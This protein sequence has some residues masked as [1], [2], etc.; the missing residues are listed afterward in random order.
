MITKELWVQQIFNKKPNIHLQMNVPIPKIKMRASIIIILLSAIVALTACTPAADDKTRLANLKKEK[1][2]ID[3]EIT[4]LEKKNPVKADS[5]VITTL[6]N[7]AEVKTEVFKHYLEIQ[8]RIESDQNI[9]VT[10]KVSGT[11]VTEVLVSRGQSVR[12]GQLLARLDKGSIPEQLDELN[13]GIDLAQTIYN[14]QKALWDQKIGTEI[15]Y[16]Q[17]KNTLE[18][19]RR[20]KATT[21]QMISNY[22]VVAPI[23]GVVDDLT[24]RVGE[25]PTPGMDGVRI[26]N[27]NKTKALADVSE[28]YLT[29]INIGDE[30]ILEFP[31][32]N[33]SMKSSVKTVGRAIN[34]VNRTFLVEFAMN[35]N[36]RELRPNM[37]AVIKINDYTNKRVVTVPISVVQNDEA[38][39][40]IYVVEESGKQKIARKRTITVGQN[41]G[42]KIEVLSGLKEN[43]KVIVMGYQ[44]VSEGTA[45]NY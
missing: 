25:V 42:G 2:K 17:S 22:N 23:D 45:I 15:A 29:K 8:G 41:Y 12:Q 38:G 7:V 10:P 36:T 26:V 4:A 11:M 1:A 19:L 3:A 18:G 21:M 14:K 16:I 37:V 31:D 32:I 27:Y 20:K 6:I 24:L 35:G 43:E 33:F 34:T 28:N 30:T 9:M 13:N 40:F 44:N 39:K 5:N